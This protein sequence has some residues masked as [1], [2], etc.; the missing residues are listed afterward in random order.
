LIEVDGGVNEK[1]IQY[2]KDADV[3][4]AGSYVF[5]GNYQTQIETLKK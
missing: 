2:C 1:T 4:V 5:Q 3:V